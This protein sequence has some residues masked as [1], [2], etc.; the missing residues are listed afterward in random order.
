MTAAL[1]AG[2]LLLAEPAPILV[3]G[4]AHG[5]ANIAALAE[6]ELG[7]FVWIPKL[8]Y[9]MGNTPWD[10]EHGIL[11]DVDACVAAGLHFVISQRRGL[12]QAVRPGGFE[13]GGD[14]S[15]DLHDAATLAEIRRR[16]GA[17]F[18]GLH[19]EELDADLV[20]SAIRPSFRARLPDVYAFDDRAGG[21]AAFEAELRRQRDAAHAAGAAYLPNL[22]VTHHLS[23]FR[24][25]AEMV[26]AEFLEHLPATELQLAYLRGGARQFRV[27]WGAWVSPW[28]W[29]QVPCGDKASWPAPQAQPGG[30]HSASALRRALYLAWVSGARLL[31]VQE[32][33][34]LFSRANGRLELGPWGV[35]LRDFWADVRAHPE[36]MEPLVPLALLVDAD[37]GW[38]PAHLWQD[39]NQAESVWGKLPV[40]R[41][42]AMLTGALGALLPG[43]A[44]TRQAVLDRRD[45]YPGCFAAT[46]L[47]PFDIL[48]SDAGAAALRAYR[49]VALVGEHRW[50]AD[51]RANLAAYVDGGGRLLLNALHLRDGERLVEDESLTGVRIASRIHA[52]ERI[53]LHAE[54]PGLAREYAEPWFALLD[55]EPVGAEV[56]ATDPAGHPVLTRH[57]RGAGEVWLTTPEY[58]LAGYGDLR[59]PL[60]CTADLLAA[61]APDAPVRLTPPADLS[62]IAARQ[63]QECVV[64]VA[65]HAGEARAATLTTPGG[66]HA[67]TL[68]AESVQLLRVPDVGIR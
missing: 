31:T 20:Q 58:L 59:A 53:Q 6:L 34:P 36:P 21:R 2:A 15:G 23:G 8:G 52:A 48:A 68:P 10:A 14:C 55:A 33:E 18:V 42:D 22:C 43:F 47:G 40:D 3:G 27:P 1:L 11:A 49:A 5:A 4:H 39:W 44:R 29:G 12:G 32:T 19:A 7:N 26:L 9:S 24:I 37:N 67:L 16:A 38:A 51:L 45:V 13:S 63:G 41:A 56:L 28:F 54:V 17:R 46:P 50:T 66:R 64:A 57:R 62:W 65:N 35:V 30:G 25:G 61:L 60:R